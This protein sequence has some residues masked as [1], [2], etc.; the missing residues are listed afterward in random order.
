MGSCSSCLLLLCEMKKWQTHTCVVVF[1]VLDLVADR[2]G[3]GESGKST[4]AKQMQIIHSKSTPFTPA[5]LSEYVP[6]IHNNIV[7]SVVAVLEYM[8]AT[9]EHLRSKNK[10]SPSFPKAKEFFSP[11]TYRHSNN[12]RCNLLC[13]SVVSNRA[14]PR[15]I[16][17][18]CSRWRKISRVRSTR[19]L[20]RS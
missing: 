13:D 20:A 15:N 2:L 4:I 9:G 12:R 19:R 14:S 1:D 16:V 5:E 3:A 10:V 18:K 8:E 7:Q 6:V 17:T 11:L